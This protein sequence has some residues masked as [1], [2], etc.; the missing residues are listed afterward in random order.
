ML[1]AFVPESLQLEFIVPECDRLS[2]YMSRE[3]FASSFFCLLFLLSMAM[4]TIPKIQNSENKRP[5]A[6]LPASDACFRW[7]WWSSEE[8][9]PALCSHAGSGK[10]QRPELFSY[11]LF[12]NVA[13]EPS[14]GI[15]PF[16]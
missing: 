1:R 3:V 10:P 5:K 8:L 15:D 9:G 14:S 6:T 12:G 2:M 4:M 13:R 16:S 7:D 11:W